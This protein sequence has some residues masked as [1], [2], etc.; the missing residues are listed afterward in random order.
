MGIDWVV[1]G[2]VV[3]FILL[4][5]GLIIAFIKHCEESEMELL[6]D[7]YEETHP[8]KK[9]LKGT[10]VN[11]AV[12]DEDIWIPCVDCKYHDLDKGC[13]D[14]WACAPNKFKYFDSD[15][16]NLKHLL[17]GTKKED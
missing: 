13:N 11:E 6:R 2:V 5:T 12:I 15:D 9:T 3:L 7:I 16:P 8:K 10:E 4:D 14:F 1:L 17:T